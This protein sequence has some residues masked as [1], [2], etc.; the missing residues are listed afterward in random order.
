M[1]AVITAKWQYEPAFQK[2]P[3]NGDIAPEWK[4]INSK[5]TAIK[6]LI[7]SK[8]WS[9]DTAVAALKKCFEAIKNASYQSNARSFIGG[10]TDFLSE[11]QGTADVRNKKDP[12]RKAIMRQ[13]N[14]ANNVFA[15]NYNYKKNTVYDAPK[16]DWFNKYA[17]QF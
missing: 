12:G 17:S 3:R 15:W 2:S 5:E 8:G 13:T 16:A 10:R 7:Y 14:R 4:N 1:K 11:N 9:R 6:A